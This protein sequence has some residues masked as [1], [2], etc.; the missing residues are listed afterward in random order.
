ME[1]ASTRNDPKTALVRFCITLEEHRRTTEGRVRTA[2]HFLSHF[3]PTENGAPDDRLFLHMPKEVRGPILSGWG[4][5]GAKA[6][7]RD[8]DGKVASVVFDALAAGDLD[9]DAFESALGPQLVLSWVPLPSF[10]SFWR[11]GAIGKPTLLLSLTKAYE[12]ELLDGR[13]FFETLR[14]RG[15]ELKG[16]DVLG[17]AL[18]K[19]ELIE[20]IRKVHASGD[21]SPKGMLETVGWEKIVQKAPTESLLGVLDALAVRLG[22]APAPEAPEPAKPE[23]ADGRTPAGAAVAIDAHGES[24]GVLS[25]RRPIESTPPPAAGDEAAVAGENAPKTDPPPPDQGD[26]LEVS[27]EAEA[28]SPTHDLG[29]TGPYATPGAR[30]APVSASRLPK[31]VIDNDEPDSEETKLYRPTQRR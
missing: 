29:K 16:T 14:A 26:V 13:A 9:A 11:A 21:A 17:T 6:A 10:W 19:D 25:A 3:F 18:N 30:S 20:W 5:R 27:G 8:D 22:L 23:Q 31:T 28:G 2:A 7:L 1:A 12:L 15:G 24:A 4:I